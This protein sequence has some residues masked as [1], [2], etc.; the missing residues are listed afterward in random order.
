[1]SKGLGAIISV[2]VV[3]AIAVGVYSSQHNNNNKS[4]AS[5]STAKSVKQLPVVI[6]G[7]GSTFAAPLYGQLG[8]EYKS[9]TNTTINYQAV[10]SGAGIAQF[11]ANTV[12]YGATDVALKDSEIAQA[13]A[14]GAPLNIPVAFG[15]V[16]V[17]YNI[18]GIKSGLKLDGPTI[19]NIYLGSITNW[20]DPAIA[21]LN[22]NLRLPDLQIAPVY[23]SDGS[24]TTSL[25]TQFL[26]D[27]SPQWAGQVGT[28]KTVK[29][30]VGTGSSGNQGVAA[31]TSQTTGAIGYVELAY[32]LQNKFTTASVK[33]KAG[34]YV[35]PS[36][37]STSK[38]GD[39]LPNLPSD[40]RFSAINSP[41]PG[42]YPIASATFIV[43]YK[44][45]CKAH[46]VT[47]SDQA[48]ALTGWLEYILGSGQQSMQKLQ[49]APLP[50]TLLTKAQ[51][52]VS[53]MTCNGATIK[54]N[55]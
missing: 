33:D 49:Y 34:Q 5:Q 26:S 53:T 3:V 4:I 11:I 10:G 41:N 45:T 24:G 14:N 19:A 35:T 1:M 12:N 7:A 30:P 22:P 42:A 6:T 29:W 9:K 23:R 36:L 20:N 47:N 28:N 38:A 46:E 17:S 51:A 25:F 50:G 39:K 15:A 40:L 13:Q 16:T 54:A 18:P 32:A 44:D 2:V 43:A 21:K 31:T 37:Q 48:E 8:S 55:N 27:V 52:M